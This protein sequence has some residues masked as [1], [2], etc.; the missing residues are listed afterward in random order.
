VSLYSEFR[1]LQERDAELSAALDRLGLPPDAP[2]DDLIEWLMKARSED[3]GG[4]WVYLLNRDIAEGAAD[5]GTVADENGIEWAAEERC[6]HRWRNYSEYG[7][8]FAKTPVVC[9][10]CGTPAPNEIRAQILDAE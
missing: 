3:K 9:R 6:E 2:V 4:Q 5:G 10:D 1:R 8:D 7:G